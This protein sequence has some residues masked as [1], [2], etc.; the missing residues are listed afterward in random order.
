LYSD[1][2]HEFRADSFLG[3]AEPVD[4]ES[5]N[6]GESTPSQT[7]AGSSTQK[8]STARNASAVQCVSSIATDVPTVNRKVA[9]ADADV[10]VD[11]CADLPAVLAVNTVAVQSA[12]IHTPLN[13]AVGE[14][15]Q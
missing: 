14:N 8:K 11:A 3:L 1:T 9:D 6:R 13:V 7:T 5:T 2:P 4:I 10:Y 12:V 15:S